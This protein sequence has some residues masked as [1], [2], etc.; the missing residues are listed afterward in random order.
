MLGSRFL[1]TVSTGVVFVIVFVGV[2][3]STRSATAQTLNKGPKTACI[4][5]NAGGFDCNEADLLARLTL[6]DLGSTET[7]GTAGKE[8]MCEVNDLWGWT[9]D[10]TGKE[11]VLVGMENGTAFVDI[12]DPITPLYLG[13]LPHNGA[14]PSIWRDVKT[15]Q[16]YAYIVADSQ[17]GNGIQVFDLLVLASH[18]GAPS[19]FVATYEYP[20]DRTSLTRAHNIAINEETGYAYVVGA[21]NSSNARVCGGGLYMV[22][23]ANPVVPEFAGCFSAGGTGLAGTGYTHDAQ[24]VVYRGPDQD[25]AGSEIC[26]S[27]NETHV[28]IADVT[29][30]SNPFT[31]SKV[32]YPDSRYIH[33]GWLTEDHKYYIQ[34]DELD[35]RQDPLITNTRT[36]I[37][38]VI[39]LDDPVLIKEYFAPNT[40][41][42]HNLY[43]K[44]SFVYQSNY[45]D[46]LRILDITDI[47]NP[48]EVAYFD[49]HPANLGIWDGS[50]SNYPFFESG[51]IAVNSSVDG[52]F[53]IELTV[54]GT[55]IPNEKDVTPSE[56]VISEA[57]PNPFNDR[58]TITVG[59]PRTQQLTVAIYDVLGRE[60]K[61]IYSGL[62]SGGGEFRLAADVD[63][64]PAGQY[65]YRVIGENF[66][67]SKPITRVK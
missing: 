49:T 32:T 39:D 66:T 42:D 19:I 17:G 48:M 28:V 3:G 61:S 57:Y 4:G 40:S 54:Q 29:D 38:D 52:L 35:E 58:L 45:V 51:A 2:S 64:L 6:E 31:I 10:E 18:E 7:C 62:V 25:H 5:G 8:R 16:N 37:W 9:D 36:L 63:D 47:M 59:I 50:W 26:M 11:Y 53:L 14:G 44:G 23:L 33:Q 22:S 20:E 56:F 34:N 60:V 13:R 12:S 43:V 55:V 65:F 41:I 67:V 1:R 21:R 27:A 30:K 24:C 15:Y 46:G